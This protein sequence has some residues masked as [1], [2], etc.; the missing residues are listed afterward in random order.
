[1][2]DTNQGKNKSISIIIGF[3]VFLL[4][5]IGVYFSIA[6]NNKSILHSSKTQITKTAEIYNKDKWKL[7]KQTKVNFGGNSIRILLLKSVQSTGKEGSGFEPAPLYDV[8]LLAIKNN[9][10]IYDYVKNEKPLRGDLRFFIDDKLDIRDVTGDRVPE[11]IFHSGYTGGSDRSIFEHILWFNRSKDSFIDV[12]RKNFYNVRWLFSGGHSFVVI[13]VPNWSSSV[14]ISKRCHIC[15]S[16]F[17]YFVY[18][19]NNNQNSFEL[20]ETINS[21]KSYGLGES[22]LKN[23]WQKIQREINHLSLLIPKM[24]YGQGGIIDTT[25][26]IVGIGNK[27]INITN[28]TKMYCFDDL[29]KCS[30]SEICGKKICGHYEISLKTQYYKKNGKYYAREIIY[31]PQ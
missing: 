30:L 25:K 8:Q 28:D 4:V 23:D 21:S 18:Q 6:R 29:R 14:P 27:D 20:Y 22:A 15:K 7:I 1:M 26:K 2:N 19:W 9:Q 13:A 17:Q 31:T 3:L 10:I 5:G 12:A 16:P 11:V 24:F